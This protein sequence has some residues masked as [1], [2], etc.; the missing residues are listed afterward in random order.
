MK[1][2]D[3]QSIQQLSKT[4]QKP[5]TDP[6]GPRYRRIIPYM[7]CTGFGIHRRLQL[8]HHATRITWQ[9]WIAK[10][11]RG[12]RGVW[13]GTF[14]GR[15]VGKHWKIYGMFFLLFHQ[16]GSVQETEVLQKSHGDFGKKK[17]KTP[18]FEFQRDP[19]TNKSLSRANPRVFLQRQPCQEHLEPIDCLPADFE[20]RSWKTH[21]K[22]VDV[23]PKIGGFLPTK[24]MV[25]NNGKPY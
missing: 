15:I 9:G 21:Q 6:L 12:K 17:T 5:Q 11:H 24:W 4:L 2:R 20:M 8:R 1:K 13:A 7:M 16:Y 14:T 3:Q 23:E 10:A 25:Q 18:S 19:K 22:H